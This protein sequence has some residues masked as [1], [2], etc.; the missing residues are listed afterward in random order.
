MAIGS[1]HKLPNNLEVAYL[2]SNEAD[3]V[4]REIFEG[5]SYS[6]YG[7]TFRDGD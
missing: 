7:I 3:A 1:L 2:N 6:K 4:Y 5:Q